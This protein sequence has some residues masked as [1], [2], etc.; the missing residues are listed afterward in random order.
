LTTTKASHLKLL[1]EFA[2]DLSR[3]FS[4]LSIVLFGSLARGEATPE[5]DA[6]TL[7][8]CDEGAKEVEREALNIS[9]D[10]TVKNEIFLQVLVMSFNEFEDMLKS[11]H[12]LACEVIYD[13]KILHDNKSRFAK[14]R[15]SWL[16][17]LRR[18]EFRI[19]GYRVARYEVAKA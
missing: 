13:G 6:D 18:E 8:L 15:K 14:L 17:V 12:P 5:S 10:L 1:D 9:F 2:S 11:G 4:D 7:I 19:E 3:E 16:K